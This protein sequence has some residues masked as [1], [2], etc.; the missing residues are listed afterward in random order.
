M[1]RAAGDESALVIWRLLDGKPGHENQTLGLANAMRRLCER[2]QRACTIYDIPVNRVQAGPVAF[3]QRKF[4]AGKD[5]LAPDFILGAGTG[6]HWSLLCAKRAY[7]GQIVVL[8]KPSLP[9]RW[10]DWVIVPEH[11]GVSAAANVITTKGVLNPMLPGE[12]VSGSVLV[13]VG[14]ESKHFE[15]DNPLVL[16][17]LSALK[18]QWS[19]LRVT[20][21]RRTP[22]E[23][24]AQLQAEFG[25]GYLP[26]EGFNSRQLAEQLAITETVFVTADSVSMVYEALTAGCD[27][28]LIMPGRNKGKSRV[29]KGVQWLAAQGWV[30]GRNSPGSLAGCVLDEAGGVVSRLLERG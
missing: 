22:S 18:K 5:L 20:D 14:G 17:E 11:D 4:S 15:W 26:W 19:N 7:G 16:G 10:F 1:Q 9:L 6:T 2:E 8:M 3:F 13:L 23:L 30:G 27:T 12:K 21:S 29:S 24:R 28:R 25:G